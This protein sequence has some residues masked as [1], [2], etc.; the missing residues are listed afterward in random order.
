M[1]KTK[2]RIQQYARD[3][4]KEATD[5]EQWLWQ[6]LRSRRLLGYK[7]R[8]QIPVG[9]YIIDFLCK[10]QKLVVELDGSQH[11]EQVDYDQQRTGYLETQGYMVVRYWN[12]EVLQHGDD[13]LE[14]I[15][16]RLQG[17]G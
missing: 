5:A 16:S 15:I 17:R 12:N 4:R 10:E 13:V 9:D 2:P 11:Q 7:F 3:L 6:Q 1:H 8:R 14:D